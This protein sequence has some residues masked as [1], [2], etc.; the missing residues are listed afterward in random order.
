MKHTTLILLLVVGVALVGCGKGTT[1][2]G[3]LYN[4]NVSR[5]LE[6]YEP[7]PL[8]AVHEAAVA[9]VKDQG[10]T[11]DKDALDAQEGIVEGKTALDKV[12]KVLTIKQ[13]AEVTR[14]KVYVGGDEAAARQLLDK[15]EERL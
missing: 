7:K 2:Q 14:L 6:V 5:Q 4:V 9:A 1:S 12:V 11:I 8:E 10:Y 13:G 3:T 15:I